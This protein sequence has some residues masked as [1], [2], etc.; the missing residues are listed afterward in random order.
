MTIRCHWRIFALVMN[1]LAKANTDN[2]PASL[3]AH[4][5]ELL[6]IIDKLQINFLRKI[7]SRESPVLKKAGLAAISLAFCQLTD[8]KDQ[9]LGK[10][11][12]RTVHHTHQMLSANGKPITRQQLNARIKRMNE[13]AKRE[14]VNTPEYVDTNSKVVDISKIKRIIPLAS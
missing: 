4:D 1:Q 13:K 6:K 7:A 8:K 9:L 5:K 3:S 2:L 12:S 10:G 11:P 14:N